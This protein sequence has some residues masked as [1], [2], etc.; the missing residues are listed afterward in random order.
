MIAS[1]DVIEYLWFELLA[2]KKKKKR[3]SCAAV[4]SIDR[5]ICYI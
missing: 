3:R 4:L 1:R 5:R 2:L